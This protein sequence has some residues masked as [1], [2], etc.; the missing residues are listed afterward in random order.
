MNN[1]IDNHIQMLVRTAQHVYDLSSE[2]EHFYKE[3]L[4]SM[5]SEA[6]QRLEKE[7]IDWLA[8]AKTYM[9]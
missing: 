4:P 5:D 2:L 8:V 6:F 1:Q 9:D 7:E 3:I